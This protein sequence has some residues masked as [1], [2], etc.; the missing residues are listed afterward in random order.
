MTNF[1]Y[2]ARLNSFKLG[3]KDDEHK[4]QHLTIRLLKR[5]IEAGL[6]QMDLNYPDHFQGLSINELTQFISKQPININGLAMF[7][8]HTSPH[9]RSVC[10]HAGLTFSLQRMGTVSVLE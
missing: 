9:V 8:G 3:L 5:A 10:S 4:E 1:S 6:T 7:V 2:G